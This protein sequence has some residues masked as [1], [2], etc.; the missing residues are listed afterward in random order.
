MTVANASEALPPPAPAFGPGLV[1]VPC[2]PFHRQRGGGPRSPCALIDFHLAHGAQALALPMH[3]GE[4]VRP[5]PRRSATGC[6][7]VR[8]PMSTAASR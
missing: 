6:S 5:S 7:S 8:S 3:A 1:H 2:T 4:S